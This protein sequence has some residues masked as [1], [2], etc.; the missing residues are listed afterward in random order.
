MMLTGSK[1]FGKRLGEKRAKKKKGSGYQ[2]ILKQHLHPAQRV[3]HDR[4]GR[5]ALSCFADFIPE[6][7]ARRDRIELTLHE[8]AWGGRRKSCSFDMRVPFGCC[9]RLHLT[10]PTGSSNPNLL[11]I[12]LGKF[13]FFFFVPIFSFFLFPPPQN[14]Q[15]ETNKQAWAWRGEDRAFAAWHFQRSG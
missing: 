15:D 9:S 10:N 1:G 4:G 3:L 14:M 2:K 8:K 5:A 6:R 7:N 12:S 13:F 11:Q